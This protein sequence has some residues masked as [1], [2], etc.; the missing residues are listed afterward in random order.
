[1]DKALEQEDGFAGYEYTE[2][3]TQRRLEPIYAGSYP[4]FGWELERTSIPPQGSAFVT[5]RFRRSRKIRNKLELTRL[6]RQFDAGV[7]AIKALERAMVSKAAVVA[8]LI[9]VAGT[10]LTAG[11]MYCFIAGHVLPGVLLAVP[12]IPG[13]IV[14]YLLYRA[15]S[16]RKSAEVTPIIE[17]KY[18]EIHSICEKAG[19]LIQTS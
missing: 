8:Y 19:Q 4:G 16:R 9:G 2:V 18:D 17:R 3:T 6:Q 12:G 10:A 1:M 13:L 5:L 15:I 7:D 11:S 14:P